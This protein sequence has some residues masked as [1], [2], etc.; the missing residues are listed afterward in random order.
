ME[1][2]GSAAA[3]VAPAASESYR[4]SY[5]GEGGAF[6]VLLLKN[7]LLTILTLG[8]Y[9]AWAK[10]NRRRYIWS[11]IELYGQRLKYT[12]TGK[13]LFIAYLK[14]LAFY[15][16]FLVVPFAIGQALGTQVGTVVQIAM[17][18]AVVVLIPFAIYWSRRFLLSRTQWRGIR[19][20][21]V[22]GAGPYAKA[23]I[24]GYLLT[25]LTLGIYGP[26]WMNDLQ[27]IMTDRSRLGSEPFHYDGVGKEMFWI[28][29]KGFLLTLV[30]LGIY[31][32]WWQAAMNRYT[33][34]HTTFSGARGRS[35]ITGGFLFLISLLNV[36][37]LTFTLGLAFPWIATY[38]LSEVLRR[39]TFEG[40]IDFEGIT[41]RAH[42]E[43][44]G[45]EALAD[46]LDV[47]L[48]V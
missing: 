9:A 35:E 48:G 46:A 34:G 45:G 41:Q 33:I 6:F 21:L 19:F 23:F 25:I 22:E 47:G 43:G 15:V 20:G 3:R 26:F 16:V 2:Q 18:L 17:G 44:A 24:G 4:F 13:E 36:L 40:S 12:G 37:G 29:L 39:I 42:V 1:F 30:T 28:C 5:H 31:G 32:F 14:L 38:T 11:N 8:I 7:I 10:T 27:R